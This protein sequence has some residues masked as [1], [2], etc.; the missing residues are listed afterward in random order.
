MKVD[1]GKIQKLRKSR[2]WSHD[3][4]ITAMGQDPI[5]KKTLV[6]VETNERASP[7]PSTVKKIADTLGVPVESLERI[8]AHT[9]QERPPGAN[10]DSSRYL[11][12]ES[13]TARV[14]LKRW[15]HPDPYTHR[16]F[17]MGRMREEIGICDEYVYRRTDRIESIPDNVSR[18]TLDW[19]STGIIGDVSGYC[20][21]DVSEDLSDRRVITHRDH[22]TLIYAISPR[23]K[24]LNASITLFNELRPLYLDTSIKTL[25]GAWTSK[26]EIHVDFSAVLDTVFAREPTVVYLRGYDER[27]TEIIEVHKEE[28]VNVWSASYGGSDVYLEPNSRVRMEWQLVP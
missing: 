14:V 20:G 15:T 7:R 10:L 26:L 25:D 13:S 24:E 28:G 4:F 16:V 19:R 5:T 22:T 12:V 2:G 11:Y 23:Q 6:R 21:T 27:P 9:K 3:N 18:V 17:E 8:E 1:G